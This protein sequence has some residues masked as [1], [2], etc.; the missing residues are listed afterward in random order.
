MSATLGSGARAAWLGQPAPD[1]EEAE[2]TPYPAL[3][4]SDQPHP[5]PCSTA[6]D[7]APAKTVE[8]CLVP[9]MDP[10]EAARFAVEAADNGA[11]VLVVRNTVKMAVATWEVIVAMAPSL[12]LE[13]ANGPALHHSRFAAEDR[14]R[15]DTAVEGA[16]GKGSPTRGLIA[17]GTQTLEQSLDIDADLLVTDL[18]P[19]DVLLQ[20]IGRLHRHSNRNRPPGFEQ[21]RVHVLCPSRGLDLLAREGRLENGLGS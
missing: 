13:V 11:R 14:R 7:T 9:T 5:L 2:R 12:L 3:W 8:P 4:R 16:L 1:L 20:R 18:C 15:L 10:E 19:I 21:A 17:V 6:S